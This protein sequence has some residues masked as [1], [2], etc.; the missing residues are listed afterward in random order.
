MKL[1]NLKDLYIHELKDLYSAEN[2][3]LQALP[4]MAAAAT[5]AD[6]QEA[7]EAHLD[8]TQEHVTRLEQVL[9]L[10]RAT[11]KGPKCKGMESL[12]AEGSSMIG[13]DGEPDVLDAG[14]IA[15]AR[16]VE[17]YEIAGYS[18]VKA[19]AEWLNEEEAVDLLSQTLEEEETADE[20]LTAI[21]MELVE[22]LADDLEEED[23][24]S[25]GD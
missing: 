22:G 15:A 8:E 16:K 21:A 7:F 10:A 6:L 11:T 24:A 9:E 4:K 13:E 3:L 20:K 2:Q 12:L 1:A 19:Y 17:H 18:T 23:E 14:L 25:V 5:S